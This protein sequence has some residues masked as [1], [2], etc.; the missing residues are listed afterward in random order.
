MADLPHQSKRGRGTAIASTLVVLAENHANGD[1]GARDLALSL[2]R[3]LDGS[4]DEARWH[5]DE[6]G[7]DALDAMGIM[8]DEAAG[9]HRKEG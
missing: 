2:V 8:W 7:D 6:H 9:F 3:W 4:Q 5:L 1:T